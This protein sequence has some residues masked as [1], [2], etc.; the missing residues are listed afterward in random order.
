M[1]RINE[2]WGV[3]LTGKNDVAAEGMRAVFWPAAVARN[4]RESWDHAG[5]TRK[6]A[7]EGSSLVMGRARDVARVSDAWVAGNTSGA[8]GRD[9]DRAGLGNKGAND[10]VCPCHMCESRREACLAR[11]VPE[12][13]RA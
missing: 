7:R 4:R 2:F 13:R 11:P 6:E 8:S 1:A 9:V 5:V 3:N 12:R 10:Y